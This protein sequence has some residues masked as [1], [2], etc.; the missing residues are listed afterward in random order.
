MQLRHKRVIIIAGISRGGT[1]ILWNILQ[2]H[3]QV[4]STIKELTEELNPTQNHRVRSMIDFAISSPVAQLPIIRDRLITWMDQRFYESKMRGLDDPYARQKYQNVLY[5]EAEMRDA[6]LCLKATDR[7][8]YLVD[9]L[10]QAY[11]DVTV[12]NIVRNG[13]AVSDSWRR[14]GQPISKAAK[15]YC[16]YMQLLLDFE[17]K[18]GALT[19]RFEDLMHDPFGHARKVYEFARLEP[20]EL[21]KIRLK[22]KLIVTEAGAHRTTMGDAGA[23]HWFTRETIQQILVAEQSS[24]QKNRLSEDDVR[25]FDQIAHDMM[26]RLGY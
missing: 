21:Q 1:N 8:L 11:E 12:I 17:E 22:A 6:I 2:S 16:H 14:R 9:M 24:I 18:Y 4:C 25:E 20:V 10:A 3:P 7:D 15:R 13:Y 23:K 19:I 5:S 26:R